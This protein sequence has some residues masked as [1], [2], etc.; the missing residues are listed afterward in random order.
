M[1]GK[2]DDTRKDQK[3]V[4]TQEADES[5]CDTANEYESTTDTSDDETSGHSS[6]ED[7]DDPLKKKK[8]KR[9]QHSSCR[10]KLLLTSYAC[11]CGNFFCALHTPPEEHQCDFDYHAMAK[12][13]IKMDNP[14]IVKKK[15]PDIWTHFRLVKFVQLLTRSI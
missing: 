2:D 9:C 8:P 12:K 1:D 13:K 11:Y 3:Q 15:V 5:V 6:E 7:D 14:K 10:T 4:D